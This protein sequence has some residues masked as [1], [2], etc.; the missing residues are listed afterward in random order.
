MPMPKPGIRIIDETIGS[1]PIV[2]PRDEVEVCFD[3]QLN[4]GDFLE[5]DRWLT[6]SLGDRDIVPGFRYG[7][8]G[9]RVGG[10]RRFKASPHLCYQ[11]KDV[12][13][14]PKDAVLVVTIKECR[15]AGQ[16]EL[17]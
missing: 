8:E 12:V 10:T 16:E 5:R 4:R 17:P 3:I 13:N 2:G 15:L 14:M 11:D 7:I 6:L 1:G 9:M